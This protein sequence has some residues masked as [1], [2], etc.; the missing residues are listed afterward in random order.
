MRI[1]GRP[2]ANRSLFQVLTGDAADA[3]R[4][5]RS[6][7]RCWVE[8]H[9]GFL[10]EERRK[11]TRR[12]QTNWQVGR[13]PGDWV[14]CG[15]E[16]AVHFMGGL[17]AGQGQPAIVSTWAPVWLAR[18]RILELDIGQ[19]LAAMLPRLAWRLPLKGLRPGALAAQPGEPATCWR[20]YIGRQRADTDM[21]S[22]TASRL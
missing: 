11:Q 16:D 6:K 5:R 12:V 21:R 10:C 19:P 20:L 17:A 15:L 4:R 9:L 18:D 14:W 22:W 2:P 3:V 1:L 8:V 13:Q 7:P